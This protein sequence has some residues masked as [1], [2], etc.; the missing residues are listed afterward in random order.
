[1]KKHIA[2]SVMVAVVLVG[3]LLSEPCSG[4]SVVEDQDQE[5]SLQG[6]KEVSVSVNI[7]ISRD[8]PTRQL[9][10]NTVENILR[11]G[12]VTVRTEDD[13]PDTNRFPSFCVDVAVFKDS[14]TS[15]AFF[16]TG[17]LFQRVLLAHLNNVETYG[18][19]WNIGTIGSG[20][21]DKILQKVQLVTTEFLRSYRNMNAE[22]S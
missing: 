10:Q 13:Q 5:K 15:Y 4:H 17:R 19:T 18:A 20:G 3:L 1:M 9:L 2:R 21:V 8:G 7:G 11:E 6:I 12:G 16:V 14:S 22:G